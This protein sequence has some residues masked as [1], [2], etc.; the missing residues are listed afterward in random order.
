MVSQVAERDLALQSKDDRQAIVC[1]LRAQLKERDVEIRALKRLHEEEVQERE[2]ECQR[3]RR[4]VQAE[5]EQDKER[6][7]QRQGELERARDRANQEIARLDKENT[8][9]VDDMQA[10]VT[11]RNSLE[12]LS[13]SLR[14]DVEAVQSDLQ[15]TMRELAGAREESR[16]A[17]HSRKCLQSAHT[18]VELKQ[19]MLLRELETSLQAS[20]LELDQ[21]KE[22]HMEAFF[23]HTQAREAARRL[24]G[25]H[26]ALLRSVHESAREAEHLRAKW[27][28]E[29]TAAAA[30]REQ[31]AAERMDAERVQAQGAA[32]M[33]VLTQERQHLQMQ[34][35][36]QRQV[37]ASCTS[38][39][40]CGVVRRLLVMV[41]VAVGTLSRPRGVLVPLPSLA[42]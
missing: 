28:E 6:H 17:A 34:L 4:R 21:I 26:A 41:C 38:T 5:R 9:L 35:L 19:V 15:R 32:Q 31:R 20:R 18:G 37:H 3:V 33:V 36:E 22:S 10:L 25:Q 14:N 16:R 7:R 11:E 8:G 12:A 30:E 42:L 29:K 2:N 13:A 39:R 23:A 24:E 40:L 1:T 27:M